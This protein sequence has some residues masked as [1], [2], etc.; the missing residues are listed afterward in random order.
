MII[1]MTYKISWS[2]NLY[3]SILFFFFLFFLIIELCFFPQDEGDCRSISFLT[4]SQLKA[5]YLHEGEE[6]DES[7][8]QEL[9]MMNKMGLPTCFFNSPCNLDSDDKVCNVSS[10]ILVS[11]MT[12]IF[13]LDLH[14]ALHRHHTVSCSVLLSLRTFIS[15][16]LLTIRILLVLCVREKL[17]AMHMRAIRNLVV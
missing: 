9:D 3:W 6:A 16:C 2:I 11:E 17:C 7:T 4:E 12:C 15:Y 10:C 8:L 13:C 14:V 1:A 5:T